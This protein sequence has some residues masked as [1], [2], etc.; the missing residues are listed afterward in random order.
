M[1]A[2]YDV[3]CSL[4]IS[5]VVLLMIVTFNGTIVEHAGAQTVRVA[6]QTNLTTVCDIMA[7][8]IRKMGYNV[9]LG[10]DS[11]IVYA[12]SVR[13]TFKGATTYGGP[14]DVITYAYDPTMTPNANAKAHILRRTFNGATQLINVGIT[15]FRLSYF[16]S[17]GSPIT[18]YPVA[19][20]RAIKSIRLALN[21]ESTTPYIPTDERYLKLTP[22]AYWERTI[23]PPNLN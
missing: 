12:D 19:N 14:V 15:Q 20:T 13:I 17:S 7:F 11:A 22:G 2:M 6:A 21:L 9:P 4:V 1:A 8:E 10:T 3:L 16:D 23:K 5:G 18:T